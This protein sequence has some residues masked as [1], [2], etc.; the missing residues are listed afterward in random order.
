MMKHI[1]HLCLTCALLSMLFSCKATSLSLPAVELTQ[2]DTVTYTKQWSVAQLGIGDK[3]E[4]VKL[5]GH[6]HSTFYQPKHPYEV[7]FNHK[8]S[9]LELPSHKHFM[10]LANFFDHSLM[11]NALAMKVAQQTSLRNITPKGH[12]ISLTYNNQ[13]QGI[14]WLTERVKDKIEHKS[15]S[16]LKYDVYHFKELQEQGIQA[17]QQLPSLPIDTLSFVDWW[18]IHELCMNAE[19][20]GPRSCYAYITSNDTLKAG[21]VWDFD[22]AFNEVGVDDGNDLRPNKFKN[23][24]P[25]PHFLQQK[26][27]RWLSVDS[28]YCTQAA[29]IKP[30]INDPHFQQLALS[31]WH[32]LRHQFVHL[33]KYIKQ[34]ERLLQ[35]QAEQDQ[36]LWN[37]KEPAR[38]DNS[39]TWKEAVKKL[40]ITYNKRIK[41]LDRVFSKQ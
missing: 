26:Q 38:F 23:M 35:Q 37:D 9:L 36:Q 39:T 16:L 21:P 17:M 10:L 41:V 1:L 30:L 20:N 13:W 4:N 6:G 8:M 11:R 32:E 3:V 18:L 22:M 5:K 33:N 27:I 31:R 7:K 2:T 25:L 28:L 29:I 14:Y 24:H 15:D 12:F 34:C 40:R 19:P